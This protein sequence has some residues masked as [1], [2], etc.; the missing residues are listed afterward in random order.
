MEKVP[1]VAI[2]S[3]ASRAPTVVQLD[4]EI[5]DDM[6]SHVKYRDVNRT[7]QSMA[8]WDHILPLQVAPGWLGEGKDMGS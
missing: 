6:G 8:V 3:S 1:Y 2:R 7:N 5:A 4:L